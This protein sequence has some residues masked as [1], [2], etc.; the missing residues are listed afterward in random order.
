MKG[1]YVMISRVSIVRSLAVVLLLSCT[2]VDSMAQTKNVADDALS[3]EDR[4][5]IKIV[6]WR[7]GEGRYH[8]WE[9]FTGEYMVGGNGRILLPLIGEIDAAGRT[10]AA[11][12][13]D[14]ADRLQARA[15]LI[16]R[17]EASVELIQH[18]PVYVIGEVDKPGQ[19]E[20][21]SALT[22]LQAVA[23]AGG[24][25]RRADDG[26]MRLERDRIGATGAL[27]SARRELRRLLA[28]QARL[29]V[30][31]DGG[32]TINV[33]ASLSGFSDAVQLIEEQRRI[34]DTRNEVVNSRVKSLTELGDLLKKEQISLDRKLQVQQRQIDLAKRELSGVGSLVE[35]GL[36]VSSR[37]FALERTAADLESRLLD[38]ETASLR[39]KQDIAKAER[40]IVDVRIERQARVAA[41]QQ[42][43]LAAIDQ[44]TARIDVAVRLV[45][46]ATQV[47]PMLALERWKRDAGAPVYS[48][49]RNVE[50]T[51]QEIQVDETTFLRP[52]DTVRVRKVS[53]GD[54]NAAL[55]APSE[56]RSET[57]Q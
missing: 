50:G 34:L 25:F 46:E 5:R 13:S 36:S 49:V 11:V 31:V 23:V 4:L 55:G 7:G 38:L 45:D 16:N 43:N 44:A 41:E 51:I 54:D 9:V 19:V 8:E 35:K 52:G 57:R 6:E 40:D 29:D 26:L 10:T 21:R 56:L 14:I 28:K 22:V 27:E 24:L 47:A 33:P 48:V 2:G 42:D 32:D 17:P 39:V 1:A 30:E 53:A 15:S 37:Q 18:R 12:S 20:Y 3:T